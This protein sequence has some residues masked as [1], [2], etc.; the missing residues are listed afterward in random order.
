M[1][2]GAMLFKYLLKR[3]QIIP[4]L[5][6]VITDMMVID[7]LTSNREIPLWRFFFLLFSF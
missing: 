1:K 4:L 3:F 5:A 2:N 7:R 6:L